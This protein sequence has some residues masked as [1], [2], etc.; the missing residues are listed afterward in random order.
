MRLGD[1]KAETCGF[2]FHVKFTSFLL[3]SLSSCVHIDAPESFGVYI[4]LN[5]YVDAPESFGVYR[6]EGIES[7]NYAPARYG[8]PPVRK[9]RAEI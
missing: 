4:E 5:I 2:R 8:I 7:P 9:P 3:H 1:W 6:T